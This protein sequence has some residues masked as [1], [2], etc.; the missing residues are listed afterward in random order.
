L[1]ASPIGMHA[2]RTVMSR[3]AAGAGEACFA[4]RTVRAAPGS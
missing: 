4:G 1:R 2:P 3:S